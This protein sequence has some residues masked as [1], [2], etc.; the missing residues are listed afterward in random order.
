[1][2]GRR[3][4]RSPSCATP[5]CSSSSST[6]TPARLAEA[7]L[8]THRAKLEEY[9]AVAEAASADHDRG[10]W[11]TLQA[12]L[13]HERTWVRFWEE[14]AGDATNKDVTERSKLEHKNRKSNRLLVQTWDI[15]L[16]L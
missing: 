11:R 9:E 15:V 7:Q 3:R 13:E 12:G 1:M 4:A 14:L 5:G 2:A 10:P 16:S 6:P 8:E